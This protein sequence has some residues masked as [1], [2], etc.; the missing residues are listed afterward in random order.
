M[1]I[2]ARAAGTVR[3]A[4]DEDCRITPTLLG[5]A[6][7]VSAIGGCV[8]TVLALRK[9]TSDEHEQCLERL[10]EARTESEKMAAELHALRMRDA[11]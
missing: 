2:P 8:S 6:A 3:L 1:G 5:L 9:A 7:V 4:A 10:R 11:S